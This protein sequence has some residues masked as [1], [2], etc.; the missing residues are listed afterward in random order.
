MTPNTWKAKSQNCLKREGTMSKLLSRA[1]VQNPQ[2]RLTSIW[3]YKSWFPKARGMQKGSGL[4]PFLTQSHAKSFSPLSLGSYKPILPASFWI[5]A[6]VQERLECYQDHLSLCISVFTKKPS[7]LWYRAHLTSGMQMSVASGEC[8][9][10]SYHNANHHGIWKLL[11]LLCL[12]S[13]PKIPW[14][15]S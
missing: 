13:S 7:V 6:F 4:C 8:R 10:S 3:W 1:R 15:P 2:G 14:A 5:K 12:N 9:C 11:G